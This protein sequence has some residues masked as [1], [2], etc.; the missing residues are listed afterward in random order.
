[1]LDDGRMLLGCLPAHVSGQTFALDLGT[2]DLD[3]DRAITECWSVPLAGVHV[4]TT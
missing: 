3:G 4:L 2:R 1:M